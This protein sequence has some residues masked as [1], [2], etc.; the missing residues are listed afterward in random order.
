VTPSNVEL[1]HHLHLTPKGEADLIT[2]HNDKIA[3][4]GI[5]DGSGGEDEDSSSERDPM[6]S[7]FLEAP[8]WMTEVS[9]HWIIV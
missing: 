4:H 5:D 6:L 8:D 7:C 2:T 9:V 3:N 1:Q